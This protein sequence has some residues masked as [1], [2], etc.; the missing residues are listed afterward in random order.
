MKI[1]KG[2]CMCGEVQFEC[3]G[4]P[5]SFSLCHC[6]MC[7]K[8]SGGP[9]GAFVGVKKKDFKYTQGE[10]TITVFKSSDWASRAFCSKCGSSLMYLYHEAP[11]NC[12]VGAGAFDDELG[13]KPKRHIFVKDKCNWF[14]ITD[15]I[16]QVQRF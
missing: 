15:N 11:E 14:D 2:S 9:F 4:E 7:Q 1:K 8:F 3:S 16:E 6:T 12:F 13:I 10:N 5:F